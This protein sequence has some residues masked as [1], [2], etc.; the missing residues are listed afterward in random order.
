MADQLRHA[1]APERDDR[2]PTR[3]GFHDRQAERFLER[4]RVQQR[5]RAAQQRVAPL[6]PDAPDVA[7]ALAVELALHLLAEVRLV[8][9]DAGDDQRVTRA[10]RDLDR[11]PGALVGVDAAEEEQVV[12]RLFPEAEPLDVDPMVNGGYV[13]ELGLPVGL[14]DRHVEGAAVVLAIDR[15]DP[16]R[17]EPVDRRHDGRPDEAGIGEREKVEVV[18]DDIEVSRALEDLGDV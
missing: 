14:A 6:G 4:D 7:N 2:R 17:G 13:V 3:H 11:F 18:V 10:A 5:Q 15:Q 16:R 12:V 1:A 9:D 8:L